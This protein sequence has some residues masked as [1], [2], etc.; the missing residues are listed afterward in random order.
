MMRPI[1]TAMFTKPSHGV[2]SG[3]LSV[4]WEMEM[5]RWS[6]LCS[7]TD[8]WH[9]TKASLNVTSAGVYL[10]A[11]VLSSF[12]RSASSLSSAAVPT[13]SAA[14]LLLSYNTLTDFPICLLCLSAVL[15]CFIYFCF[16]LPASIHQSFSTKMIWSS[17][18]NNKS[19]LLMLSLRLLAFVSQAPG[20]GLCQWR[21]IFPHKR[22]S[23]KE[24]TQD[25]FFCLM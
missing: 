5:I 19:Y 24:I 18:K 16:L 1:S 15:L 3:A 22:S 7:L 23:P 9:E 14:A 11:S 13:V 4:E 10:W 20:N 21:N 12:S 2:D 8:T 25:Y 17:A 6:V